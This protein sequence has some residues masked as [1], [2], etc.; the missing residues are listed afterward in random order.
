M[1]L[2]ELGIKPN[3]KGKSFRQSQYTTGP[4]PSS[5]ASQPPDMM[6][7]EQINPLFIDE[8]LAI[9]TLGSNFDRLA[10]SMER[11]GLS[12]VFKKGKVERVC[13]LGGG[14]GIVGMW[15]TKNSK[16][17]LCDVVD[18]AEKPLA[19]GRIWAESCG[20]QRITFTN[21]SY[22]ALTVSGRHDF[23]FVFA[24]H[25]VDLGYIP[26]DSDQAG[27]PNGESEIQ[28]VNRYR[29]LVGA[30]SSLL[31]GNGVGL[32]GGGSCTHDSLL[33]LCAALRERGMIIDWKLSSNED[34]LQLYVRPQGQIVL[35]SPD[36]EALA[37]LSDA[38]P[39]KKVPPAEACSLE[40]IFRQGKTF[41]EVCS[42]EDGVK[43]RCTLVQCAGLAC[44]FQ[45]SSNGHEVATVLSAA[46]MHI[47]ARDILTD[48]G[49]RSITKQFIDDR[50]IPLLD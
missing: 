40:K 6:S 7:A 33:L 3:R 20:F 12:P 13:D 15:L 41:A 5:E 34:G 38:V 23:D 24:E 14:T 32:I 18:H 21:T 19:V 50:L 11:V 30:F 16:C 22:A 45:R 44:V 25:G 28:F 46:K 49:K 36:D 2:H 8:Q 39:P 29:E 42:V 35:D 17:D 9:E 10:N 27:R 48:A 31:R 47:W 1:F 26:E 43:Y 37:I 4:L